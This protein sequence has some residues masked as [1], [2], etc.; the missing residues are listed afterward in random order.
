M[1]EQKASRCPKCRSKSEISLPL[2]HNKQLLEGGEQVLPRQPSCHN[3]YK[4]DQMPN[5]H[6]LQHL[7]HVSRCY[8]DLFLHHSVK[9][10]RFQL[11][12]YFLTEFST[13][14][15]YQH[16]IPYSHQIEIWPHE[17]SR[18]HSMPWNQPCA[19]HSEILRT[20]QNWR[21]KKRNLFQYTLILLTFF[22]TGTTSGKLEGS[23]NPSE[24]VQPK[25]N[26]LHARNHHP[27]ESKV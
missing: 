1:R 9:P 7:L 21:R 18:L 23:N 10:A 22:I 15:G 25:P 17:M 3:W 12:H 2:D 8:V 24:Q 14:Q 5:K 11:R 4:L 16:F 20:K 26:S 13:K 6:M 27:S 19:N